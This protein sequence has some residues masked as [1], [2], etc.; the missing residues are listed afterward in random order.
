MEMYTFAFGNRESGY[1]GLNGRF[2]SLKNILILSDDEG[3]FGSPFVDS[4]E[5]P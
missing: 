2:N 5:L 4:A 3:P 1:D